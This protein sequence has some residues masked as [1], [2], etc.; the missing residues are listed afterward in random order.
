M[1]EFERSYQYQ[2]QVPSNC[3]SRIIPMILDIEGFIFISTKVTY[4]IGSN[5]ARV[6]YSI[7]VTKVGGVCHW[8]V[9]NGDWYFED[10]G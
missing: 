7:P 6:A 10:S 4:H 3:G 5:S 8:L 1:V 9:R 2:D